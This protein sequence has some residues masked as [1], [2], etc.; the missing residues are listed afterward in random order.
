MARTFLWALFG[1]LAAVAFRPPCAAAAD[2]SP[3][4]SA[5]PVAARADVNAALEA[6]A[7][8]QN[9]R[10]SELLYQAWL[11]AGDLPEANW[12]TGRV[13]VDDGWLPLG[14]A[15]SRAASD[16][17]EAKYQE[18]RDR[19]AGSRALRE[20]ARWSQKHGMP[21]RAR[22]HYAQLLSDPSSDAAWQKEAIATL[23]LEQVNG[24]WF[25]RE[26]LAERRK[27]FTEAQAAVE[28]WLPTDGDRRR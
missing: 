15:V 23:G 1:V 5:A 14:E 4:E 6:E 19:A 2:E 27:Q 10:R 22:L 20:L 17:D 18:L 11:A 28:K 3:K 16:A 9:E 21:D 24:A 25:T 7:A 8:G 12:H 13:Q 26:E